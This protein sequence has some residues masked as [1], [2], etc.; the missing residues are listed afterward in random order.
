MKLLVL[1]GARSGKSRYAEARAGATGAARVYVATADALDTEMAARIARHQRDRGP[2][3]QTVDAPIDLAGCIRREAAPGRVLLVDCLTLWLSNLLLAGADPE[4]AAA[5]LLAA[6]AAA[7]GDLIFVSNEVGGGIVPANTLAR[8]FRDAAGRL[9][10]QMAAQVD[11]VQLVVA[12]L[13][14]ALKA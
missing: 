11:E 6:T 10:Q 13:P 14:L 9:N 8:R 4:A 2:G 7:A 5:E 12:G 1:G 3:W